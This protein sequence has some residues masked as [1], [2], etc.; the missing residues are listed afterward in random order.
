MDSNTK[1]QIIG[2]HGTSKES[3]ESI[4]ENNFNPSKGG[5]ADWLGDG[6][7]FFSEGISPAENNATKWAIVAAYN[8][9]KRC[10]DYNEY[11]V[12]KA[13]IDLDKNRFLDLTTKDGMEL[14]NYL[15]N[16]YIEKIAKSG[17]RIKKTVNYRDFKDGH[18]INDARANLGIPMDAVRGDFY[19]KFEK[20]RIYD[21]NFRIPN[22]TILSVINPK[23]TIN[24]DHI[25]IVKTREI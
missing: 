4:I 6:V 25:Q 13:E 20:E 19:I 11:S 14:F 9:Y 22:V 15:R 16:K 8:K 17:K 24:S 7:Y 5:D 3:A 23:K 12:L 10:N 21:I 1:I 2:Y 18:L